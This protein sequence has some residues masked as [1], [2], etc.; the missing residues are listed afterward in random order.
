MRSQRAPATRS[1]RAA[2]AH[3][4]VDLLDRGEEV[5]ERLAIADLRGAIRA[6][7]IEEVEQTQRAAMIGI[8]ADL[9]AAARDL[10]VA[11]AV[12]LDDALAALQRLVGVFDIGQ[13]L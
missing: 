12:I 2:A 11:G 5:R 4:L 7:G 6:L 10:E 9:A 8:F 1:R 3:R 13:H